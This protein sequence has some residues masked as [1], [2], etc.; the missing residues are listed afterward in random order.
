MSRTITLTKKAGNA[1]LAGQKYRVASAI[2]THGGSIEFKQLR[3]T[4]RSI[5]PKTLR[6]RVR[7]LQALKLVSVRRTA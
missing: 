6:A 4:C 5:K 7:E 2:A 1:E 3:K